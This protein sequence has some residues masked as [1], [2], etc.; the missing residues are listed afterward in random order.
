MA[1][2]TFTLRHFYPPVVWRT[3]GLARHHSGGPGP[4]HTAASLKGDKGL[5]RSGEVIKNKRGSNRRKKS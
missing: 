5:C 2:V 3:G 1:A 4:I